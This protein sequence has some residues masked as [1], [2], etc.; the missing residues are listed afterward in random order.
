MKRTFFLTES[1]SSFLKLNH[2]DWKIDKNIAR[3]NYELVCNALAESQTM[4]KSDFWKLKKRMLPNAHATDLP[5]AVL[6][7]FGNEI[8]DPQYVCN[9]YRS[10]LKHRSRHRDAKD[11][12]EDFI[13][14]QNKL[15]D[16]RLKTCKNAVSDDFTSSDIKSVISEF[17]NG[18]SR[19]QN[20]LIREIFTRGG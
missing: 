10:K 4:S 15:C 13:P 18:K 14:S 1:K 17:K 11:E 2:L 9:E 20:E 5:H 7:N 16:I 6:D 8:T 12:Y 19:D 3:F